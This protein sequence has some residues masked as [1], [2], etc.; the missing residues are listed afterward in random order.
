[1]KFVKRAFKKV[2]RT[3]MKL[4]VSRKLARLM[5]NAS[6]RILYVGSKPWSKNSFDRALTDELTRGKSLEDRLMAHIREAYA[7]KNRVGTRA[8]LQTLVEGPTTKA[9]GSLGFG[10]FLALDGLYDSAAGYFKEAGADISKQKAPFEYFDTQLT[11]AKKKALVEIREILTNKDSR[12][13]SAY[14]MSLIRALIK[15]G[16][17]EGLRPI[18]SLIHI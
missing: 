12:R 18:L 2:V 6:E 13:S 7:S 8:L 17:Y 14:K 1:M 4:G 11:V 9:L 3:F 16:E 15:H 5:A 10:T